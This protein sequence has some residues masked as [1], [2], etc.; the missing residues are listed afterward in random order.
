MAED[1]TRADYDRARRKAFLNDVVSFF[2]REPNTLIS[3]ADVRERVTMEGESYRGIQEVPVDK[4]VGSMDRYR[5]FDRRFLP[6]RKNTANRWRSIDR[7]YYQDVVLPPVQLY[8]VGDIYFV[9]DGN[10][11]VSVARERGVAF[12]DAEVIEG[13]IRIP[14]DSSMSPGRLLQQVE[15]AEFLRKTNLDR[16]RPQHDIRPTALG[17]YDEIITHIEGRR[18]LAE[19]RSGKEVS[20]AEAAADWYDTVYLPI[21]L[22]AREQKLLRD[23]PDRTEADIYLWVMANRLQIQLAAGSR[24]S[25]EHSARIYREI[26]GEE[27]KLKRIGLRAL[28][29]TRDFASSLLGRGDSD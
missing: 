13:H 7:A 21:A 14:I 20:L 2:K 28:N 18:R 5:D 6:K 23:F 17:R 4:I 15:Y 3:Y 1:Q 9:K 29:A 25:P 12:I 10:H 27:R 24:F 26:E 22:A 8:K 11:R 16:T 19:E